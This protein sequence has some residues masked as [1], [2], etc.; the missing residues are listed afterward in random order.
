VESVGPASGGLRLRHTILESLNREAVSVSEDD[1]ERSPLLQDDHQGAKFSDDQEY[2]YRLWRTWNHTKPT[3]TFV[4]LNPSTA[5][6]TADDP[7]IRRCI[8]FAQEWGYGTLEVVNLFG[9][10]AT[11]PSKLQEHN[12][13]IGP[14]NDE[15]LR[16]ACQD[17]EMVVVAWG[18]DGSLYGRE[19]EV[20]EMLS[21]DLYALDTT[22]DNHPVHPLY[23]PADTEPLKW[24]YD[25]S[26]K[27][28]RTPDED[29]ERCE[30]C[31]EP[32]EEKF[33]EPLEEY[34]GHD[35]TLCP[36][37]GIHARMHGE[38]PDVPVQQGLDSSW[39]SNDD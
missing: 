18:A 13:P 23:Q 4:M 29:T 19:R 33:N 38:L 35:M 9:L 15:F 6:E 1:T 21:M 5:G 11:D 34:P 36:S 32:L 27:E 12:A 14:K 2:R 17:A 25:G 20:T 28:G 8:N 30:N 3:I 10:R 7:T 24:R 37:C 26:T 39:G 22:K 16:Q 31:E